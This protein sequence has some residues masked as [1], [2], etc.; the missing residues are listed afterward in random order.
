MTPDALNVDVS[1][2]RGISPRIGLER[3]A[4]IEAVDEL[5]SIAA[6]AKRLGLSYKGA[7]DIVQAPL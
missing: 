1:L 5:G 2:R 7:W 3:V 6:A 4:L